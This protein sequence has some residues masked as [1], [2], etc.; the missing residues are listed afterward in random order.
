LGALS[1]AELQN[2]TEFGPSLPISNW[3]KIQV[4]QARPTFKL[5]LES[6]S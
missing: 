3:E 5:N 4:G 6:K 2:L 1:P